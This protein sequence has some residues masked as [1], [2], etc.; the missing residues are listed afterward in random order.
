LECFRDK[1]F[2]YRFKI[3]SY[4]LP[5]CELVRRLLLTRLK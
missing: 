1:F 4:N 5:H 2:T 3:C